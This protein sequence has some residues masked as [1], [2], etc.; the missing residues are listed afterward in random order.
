MR[1]GVEC[2]GEW[3]SG[4]ARAG[5]GRGGRGRRGASRAGAHGAADWF[6]SARRSLAAG[7]S[8]P[9]PSPAAGRGERAGDRGPW[10]GSWGGRQVPL[11]GERAG[12]RCPL[13]AGEGRC[14]LCE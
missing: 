8:D 10:A 14:P 6:L 2:L 7:F 12:D 13:A 5:S 9:E 1:E 11:G 3:R 4:G